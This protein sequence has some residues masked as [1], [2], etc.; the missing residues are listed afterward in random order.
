MDITAEL[1]QVKGARLHVERAGRGPALVLISG[2]GGDAAMY[3]EIV[4]LLAGRFTVITFDRRGNSR[5]PLEEP[6]GPI[7]VAEQAEDVV[8]VLDHCGIDR[9]F[10]FGNSGGAIIVVELVARHAHRLLGAVAHEPPLVQVLPDDSPERRELQDIARLGR[11]K[12]VMR[13]FAAFGAM[14][15]PDPPWIFR[16]AWGRAAIA[17]ASRVGLLLGAVARSVTRREPSSMTRILGNTDL[18]IRRELPE[19][20]FAYRPD[21]PA[22]GGTAVRWCT[23]VGDDSVGR[24]YHRPALVLADR[25][26]VSCERFPGGHTAYQEGPREFTTRLLTILDRWSS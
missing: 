15:L 24:P 26:G 25:L 7:G 6:G 13:A 17:V 9:A 5:S 3:E 22:L 1:I 8:S 4:P 16:S 12:G 10:V 14:T 11:E 20:C 23:A 19:F 18:L 21:L 2:G